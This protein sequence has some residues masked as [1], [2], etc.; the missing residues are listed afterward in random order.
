MKTTETIIL[1]C[2]VACASAQGQSI[3]KLDTGAGLYSANT[4]AVIVDPNWTVSL[5]GTV[6]AGKTPP[7]G[8]P[9]GA[10]YLVPNTGF[11]IGS[12]WLANDA[13]STWL[14]YATPTPVGADTTR[15]T[16]QYQMTF[17]AGNSGLLGINFLGDNT[18]ELIING[19]DLGSNP[20]QFHTWLAT[21]ISYAVTEGTTYVVDL[22]VYNAPRD[23][24]QDPTGA[25]VQFTGDIVT[26]A[27]ASVPEESSMIVN[28]AL[29]ALPFSAGLIRKLRKNR[30]A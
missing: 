26:G 17:T 24:S 10:A 28:A 18:D 30:A 11:P 12:S 20:G 14:T 19:E 4:G 23:D 8:I 27:S 22:D 25:R 6:P 15:D 9:T 3:S 21:P 16:F 5:L 13:T 2:A 1:L 29:L 7:G